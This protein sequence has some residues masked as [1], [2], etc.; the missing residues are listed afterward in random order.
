MKRRDFI[1]LSFFTA[2]ALS[3]NPKLF[4][5]SVENDRIVVLIELEGGNDGLNTVIPYNDDK[6]YSLRKNLA[7]KKDEVIVLDEKLG[8][9]PKMQKFKEIW[10]EGELAVILGVGYKN[11]NRSHFR[12]IEIWNTA[13][14]SDE[15]LTDGWMGKIL[16]DNKPNGDFFSDTLTMG[17]DDIKPFDYRGVDNIVLDSPEKFV[18]KAGDV[19]YIEN[20]DTENETLSYIISTQNELHNAVTLLK[21]KL[22]DPMQIETEFPNSKFANNLKNIA[23]LLKNG[24]KAP[25]FKVALGGFDT[26]SNQAPTHERLLEE[27]SSSLNSFRE[28]LKEIGYWDKTLIM[29]YSEFGRR[30][31][32]NASKGTDHGTAAPH[33]FL[34]GKVKGGFYSSQPSLDD[35]DDNG[36]LKYSVDYR[37]LYNTIVKKWWGIEN[38]F[39]DKYPPIECLEI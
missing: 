2:I 14:D 16:Y 8:F 21:E 27:L 13:S 34:G 4:A 9:H 24:I 30:P 32:E 37:S 15:Y 26:H 35:L 11:P 22:E 19:P 17:K 20:E 29:T 25:V 33:F 7:V 18:K 39:L 28:A 5:D 38:S 36:D 1:K 31:S 12:S 6:Y 3:I 23:F 10:D